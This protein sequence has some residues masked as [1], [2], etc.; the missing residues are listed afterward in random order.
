M[1]ASVTHSSNSGDSV[2]ERALPASTRHGR[3]E[4]RRPLAQ[5]EGNFVVGCLIG[6]AVAT[7]LWVAIGFAI[8]SIL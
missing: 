5:R 7:A 6:V 1:G 8:Y 3:S 4:P 2:P